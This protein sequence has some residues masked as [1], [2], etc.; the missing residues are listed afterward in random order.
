M[1]I[2]FLVIGA[3]PTNAHPVTGA[4]IKQQ[5]M[6]GKKLIVLD[7]VT[8]DVQE[9]ADYH[10]RLRPGTNVAVFKYDVVFHRRI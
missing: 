10:I 4:K 2:Y 1:Q 6:K 9:L 3:N 8:T 7:P 5:V